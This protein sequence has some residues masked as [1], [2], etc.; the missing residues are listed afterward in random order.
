MAD[1]TRRRFMQ[2]RIGCTLF[3]VAAIIAATLMM[4]LPLPVQDVGI[5]GPLYCGPGATSDNALQIMLNPN[6]VNTDPGVPVRQVSASEKQAQ[7]ATD[8]HNV[9]SC[10]TA[11]KTRFIPAMI[12]LLLAVG[13]GLAV[14]SILRPRNWPSS[15]GPVT[16]MDAPP[17]GR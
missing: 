10:Q 13:G 3:G 15:R 14:P 12:A 9:Q 1:L 11:A 5:L 16:S 6:E 2:L 4:L 7:D 8:L 17:G